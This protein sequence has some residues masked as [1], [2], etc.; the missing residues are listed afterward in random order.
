M[1]TAYVVSK[2]RADR[3]EAK[4]ATYDH[5]ACAASAKQK[6]QSMQGWQNCSLQCAP[7]Q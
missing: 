5:R 7:E 2:S 3:D 6:Q 4:A 1:Q